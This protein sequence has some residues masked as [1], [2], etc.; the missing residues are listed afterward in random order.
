M[1]LEALLQTYGYPI[2]FAG[3][4]VE[5][6]TPLV[7]AGFLVHQGYFALPVVIGVA[8]LGSFSADQCFFFLNLLGGALWS[9]SIALVAYH[10]TQADSFVLGD[11]RRYEPGILA[12]LLLLAA[13][14]WS[15]RFARRRS[16]TP[17]S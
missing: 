10:S 8:F 7:L 15:I 13:T 5:G 17:H 2:L 6:E 1:T 12:G 16:A 9:S 3:T 14:I 4:F 11:L